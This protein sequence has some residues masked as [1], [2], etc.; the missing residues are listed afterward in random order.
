MNTDSEPQKKG[1]IVH[2][3]RIENEKIKKNIKNSI[4]NYFM[5]NKT[6]VKADILQKKKVFKKH[7]R[8]KKKMYN[9]FF[10]N[11]DWKFR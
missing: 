9:N 10:S 2:R 1:R 6:G 8:H 11:L 3:S 7:G 4:I 5:F